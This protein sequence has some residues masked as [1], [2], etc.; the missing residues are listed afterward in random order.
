LIAV[1]DIDLMV[2][3]PPH[4]TAA[5]GMDALTHAV[6]CLIG[7]RLYLMTRELALAAVK[8]VFGIPAHSRE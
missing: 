8:L 4:I 2:N 7:R 3:L 6:E 5:T 1:N